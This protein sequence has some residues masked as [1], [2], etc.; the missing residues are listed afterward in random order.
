M[1]TRIESIFLVLIIFIGLFV[2]HSSRTYAES[3]LHISDPKGQRAVW[4]L[5]KSMRDGEAMK[6]KAPQSLKR[7]YDPII[8]FSKM[9]IQK[10]C[11]RS[12]YLYTG[13]MSSFCDRIRAGFVCREVAGKDLCRTSKVA[14]K[15][16][17]RGTFKHCWPSKYR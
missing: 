8:Y 7:L 15:C 16:N 1:V 11:K 2:V 6:K 3:H 14:G 17:S 12:R 4:G 13:N 5:Y 9:N 10:I